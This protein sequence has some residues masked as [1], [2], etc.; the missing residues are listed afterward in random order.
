MRG[1]V[2]VVWDFEQQLEAPPRA[3]DGTAGHAEPL[4]RQ[5]QPHK[6][7]AVSLSLQWEFM[8]DVELNNSLEGGV[9]C[10][11]RG[12]TPVLPGLIFLHSPHLQVAG[13][14]SLNCS[15]LRA[16]ILGSI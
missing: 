13:P 14:L 12:L 15:A 4:R 6:D 16:P 10:V 3:A 7:V 1:A 9:K 8:S 2:W 11:F 5:F